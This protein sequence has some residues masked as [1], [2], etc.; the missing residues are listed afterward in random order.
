MASA[1]AP[2]RRR[3]IPASPLRI[4][5]AT[6]LLAIAAACGQ[7]DTVVEGVFAPEVTGT[8]TLPPSESEEVALLADEHTACVID[9]YEVRVRCVDAEGAVVGVFGRMGEGPGEFADSPDLVRGEEGTLGAVDLRL[10]RFTVFEPSGNPV[11]DVILPALLFSPSSSFGDVLSGV[12]LDIGAML[13]EGSGSL[14]NRLDVNIA[15]GE[16]VRQEGSPTGP[17]DVECGDIHYG[18]ADREDGWVFVACEGHLVFVGAAGE[19]TVLRAPRYVLEFP[20]EQEVAE[21]EEEYMDFNRQRGLAAAMGIEE[22]L[23]EYRTTPKRYDLGMS[24]QLFDDAD[25]YWIATQRDMHEWSYLDVYRNAAY[26]GSVKVRDRLRGFDLAGST[27]VVLVDRQVGPDD[28]DG[29]P[30]RALDWYDIGNLPFG[31]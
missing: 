4:P 6:A 31:G 3:F 5:T 27:L 30:D 25:R 11:S 23:E 18:I 21:R 24:A 2:A 28:A 16:V 15:S 1:P 13:G 9:S 12:S 19:A 10:G 8:V 26:V 29:I 14:M 22:R 17:W 7:D 20:D